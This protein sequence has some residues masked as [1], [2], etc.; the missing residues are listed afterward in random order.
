MPEKG[1][2]ILLCY[3]DV[4]FIFFLICSLKKSLLLF[5]D[6]ICSVTNACNIGTS[7]IT[8]YV[9][10]PTESVP[11]DN[12]LDSSTEPFLSLR[13]IFSLV[14]LNDWDDARLYWLISNAILNHQFYNDRNAY[15]FVDGD[16]LRFVKNPTQHYQS[17]SICSTQDFPTC[18]RW[19]RCWVS[20]EHYLCYKCVHT[21]FENWSQ[22]IS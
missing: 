1:E 8:V 14:K 4:R 9:S 13:K 2:E 5:S 11:N 10:F 21:L 20:K 7:L 15:G 16:F 6:W 12:I 3:R 19:H 17:R 18:E 22:W